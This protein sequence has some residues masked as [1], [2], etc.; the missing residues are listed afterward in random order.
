[1][2]QKTTVELEDDLDWG[3]ADETVRF[4]ADGAEYD[5]DLSKKNAA[6]FRRMLAPFIERARKPGRRQRR[7]P[8]RDRSEPGPQ[9]SIRAWPRTRAL[10]STRAGASPASVCARSRKHSREMT[11][12]TEARTGHNPNSVILRS[13]SQPASR[14]IMAM[15]ELRAEAGVAAVTARARNP[16]VQATRS[17]PKLTSMGF[18]VTK[19]FTVNESEPIDG[20]VREYELVVDDKL[21][22]TGMGD[23]RTDALLEAIA[24]VTDQGDELPDN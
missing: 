3:L 12:R 10:W 9:R 13:P 6:A 19:T 14:R 8:L 21:T 17:D 20:A 23:D 22:W 15:T 1:M 7:R 5:I 11:A 16:G 18:E 4:A 2:A 24:H